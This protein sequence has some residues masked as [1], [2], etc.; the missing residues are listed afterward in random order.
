MTTVYLAGPMSG[1]PQ[2]NFPQFD[3]LAHSLRAQVMAPGVP[4]FTV[5]S[6]TE[7]ETPEIRASIL[8]SP[9]GCYLPGIANPPAWHEFLTRDV[10]LIMKPGID[11]ICVLPGWERSKGARLE[12]FTG[13]VTGK[14]IVKAEFGYNNYSVSL[15]ELSRGELIKGLE[16]VA[17]GE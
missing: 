4:E 6:P 9:D 3:A 5:I 16:G 10:A 2:Y 15:W 7:L 12:V 13:Y 8:A 14:K 1:I 17:D 11:A